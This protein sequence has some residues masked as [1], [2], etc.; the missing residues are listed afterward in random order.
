MSYN[1]YLTAS[2][3]ALGGIEW[4]LDFLLPPLKP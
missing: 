3:M 1:P 2:T 4:F